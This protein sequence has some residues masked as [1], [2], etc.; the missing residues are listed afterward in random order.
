MGA[1]FCSIREYAGRFDDN[2]NPELFPRQPRR[3][4]LIQDGYLPA[5]DL[6]HSLTDFY[7]A[8]KNPVV[9]IVTEQ[10]CIG[11]QI[12]HVVDGDNIQIVFVALQHRPQA[13]PSYSAKTV[14]AYSRSHPT[15]L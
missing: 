8:G 11:M 5:V 12:G 13:Q 9:R 3:I 2:I 6:K 4:E 10:V 15:S 1:K 14:N 7:L